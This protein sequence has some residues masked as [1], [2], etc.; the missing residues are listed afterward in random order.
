MLRVDS[1][2]V[3]TAVS[4]AS[5]GALNRPRMAAAKHERPEGWDA[6]DEEAGV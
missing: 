3:K 4:A 6:E 1:M 5:V 2:H